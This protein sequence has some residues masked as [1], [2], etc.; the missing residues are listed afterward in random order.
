MKN[1]LVVGFN[2]HMG[3]IVCRLIEESDD[4]KVAV[5]FDK[6]LNSEILDFYEFSSTENLNHFLGE[7]PNGPHAIDVIIDFSLPDCTLDILENVAKP[8]K[9][10]TV[11]ATTG[12]TDEQRDKIYEYSREFPIFLSSNMSS[13]IKILTDILKQVS[14]LLSDCDIEIVETHHNR[15]KD[16]PSGTAKTLADTINASLGGSMNIVYGRTGKREKNEIGI[17]SLR[18]GNIVG[19]HTVKFIGPFDSLEIKHTA[20][21]RDLFAAGALNAARFILNLHTPCGLYGM[22]DM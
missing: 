15:K 1:V 9:I 20:Y 12:F 22:N 10:P 8:F 14:P 4:F 3:Q 18:G 2:G 7:T 16:A 13:E 11:I 17:A 21:K 6:N 19:E 5:G